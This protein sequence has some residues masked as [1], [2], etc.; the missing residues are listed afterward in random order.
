MKTAVLLVAH[1]TVEDVRDLPAFLKNVRR[2]REAPPE[3][4]A[5]MNKRYAAI[6]GSSPL[7][8][9]TRSVAAKLEARTGLPVRAAMRLWAPYPRDVLAQMQSAGIERVVVLALAQFSTHVYVEAVKKDLAQLVRDGGRQMEIVA[10]EAWG[11]DPAL[12]DA[13]AQRIRDVL[14][15]LPPATRE[16]TG[17]VL[18]AHSLPKHVI[19]A[20]DPYEKEFLAAV[21]GIK[22]R[23]ANLAWH[24]RHA[25][26]SAGA[27]GGD[28]LGPDLDA[29][30]D[31]A[32]GAAF[33]R[34]AIAPVGFLADHLEILYDI[35]IEAK[36]YASV[37][38]I[39]LVRT[40]SLND[41]DDFIDVLVGL[42]RPYI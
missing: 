14:Q 32:K 23:I 20:G 26:Q 1:G 6:G 18:T 25:F 5:E 33:A 3:L 11:S 41:A 21:E 28:W 22:Q 9:I 8:A 15:P 10:I 31:A 17:L 35:D 12:L 16:K 37:L 30:I 40:E 7:L 38:G 24:V 42:V 4:V 13:Q 27:D 19:D 2:G 29:T 39:E 36:T 34:L